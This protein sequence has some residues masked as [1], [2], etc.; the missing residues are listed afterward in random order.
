MTRLLSKKEVRH[1]ILYSPAHID[2]LEKAGLFPKRVRLGQGR[3]GWVEEEIED[4][5]QER[6]AQRDNA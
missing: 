4:Y 5:I 1:R 3:V 6:I 2:R